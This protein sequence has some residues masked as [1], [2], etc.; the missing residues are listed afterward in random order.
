MG[1]EDRQWTRNKAQGTRKIQESSNN[2]KEK[3]QAR[4]SRNLCLSLFKSYAKNQ[5]T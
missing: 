3:A 5:L 4:I 1:K 2:K